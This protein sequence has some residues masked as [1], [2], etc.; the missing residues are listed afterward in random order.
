MPLFPLT[1]ATAERILERKG[2]MAQTTHRNQ[3]MMRTPE[4]CTPCSRSYWISRVA[5]S[6]A[7]RA[8]EARL[9]Y[10]HLDLPL[11]L[12]TLCGQMFRGYPPSSHC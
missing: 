7:G 2:M 9:E 8:E 1:F 12:P 3:K 10:I 6:C 5:T 4:D 11:F